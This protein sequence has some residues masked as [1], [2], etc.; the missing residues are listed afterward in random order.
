[1]EHFFVGINKGKR[2]AIIFIPEVVSQE[3]GKANGHGMMTRATF[4][5]LWDGPQQHGDL[6][7]FSHAL[8]LI[9]LGCK[10]L[11]VYPCIP[12]DNPFEFGTAGL[13]GS[14]NQ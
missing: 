7:V 3:T 13:F 6:H 11:A 8:I 2:T 14:C 12:I 1:M 9:L 5:I 4:V 10:C